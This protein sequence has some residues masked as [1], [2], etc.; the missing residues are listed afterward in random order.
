MSI[1]ELSEFTRISKYSRYLPEKQRRESWK[2]Q[3]DRMMDMHKTHLESLEVF[4]NVKDEWAFAKDMLMKKRVLGSQRALQFGGDAT[5]K[6]NARIYNC[7]R[8]DTEF[9]TIN[10][11]KSFYD[12]SHGD[13]TKVLT[14][15]GEWKNAIVKSYGKQNINQITLKNG[16]GSKRVY[17]TE[18]H[19]WILNDGS[20]TENLKI[21]DKLYKRPNIFN[22][23]NYDDATPDERLYWSYGFIYGDGTTLKNKDGNHTYSMVRLC[24]EKIKYKYRFEELNFKT[25]TSNS[26]N[27]DYMAY[28]GTYLKTLPDPNIDDINILRAFVRGFLDADGEKN[29]NYSKDGTGSIFKTIQNSDDKA[30]E[31]IRKVFPVVGVYINSESDIIKD[32][33][34]GKLYAKKFSINTDINKFSPSWSVTD[35]E[36]N[37]CSETVWCLEVDDNKS[38]VMPNGIVTGNCAFHYADRIR[39]FQETMYMALCGCGVGYSVQ[40]H[41]IKKLPKIQH[42]RK[43]EN[44][45]YTI[46]DSIEGWADAIGVLVESFFV[47]KS[48]WSGY[49]VLFDY[50][51]IRPAGAIIKSSGSK[52]PG[53]DGLRRTIDHIKKI[54]Y[55]ALNDGSKKLSTLQVHDIICHIADAVVSGGIR[56]AALISLFSKDDM[57]MRNC[58]TGKWFI[59]NPQ[60]GRANNSVLLI[61]DETTE[62]EFR[63]IITSV[64]E[65]GEPGF[66]FSD[67][68]EIGYNP[69]AEIGLYPVDVESGKSGVEFCNLSEINAKKC[70][71]LEDFMDSA[72]AAAILGTFQA[73]YSSFP[74]LGEITEKIVAKEALLGV[75]ITGMQDNPDIVLD[76]TNQR[77]AAQVVKNTNKEIA[78]KIGI[79]QA[80]RT[81]TVKP[82]GTSSIILSTG[83]SGIHPNHAKRYIRR[84]QCNNQEEPLQFFKKYNPRAIEKSV[85]DTNGVTDVISFLCEVPSQARTKNDINALSLLENVKS[86]WVNWV[87]EGKNQ[88]LC[89][90][91]SLSHNVSNTINILEGEWETVAEYIYYNRKFFAGISLLPQEGDKI[92]PQA[93]F[94]TV[95]TPKEL[96][97][98][99][100]DASVFAS[101]LIIHA[102]NAFDKNLYA[103]CDS[104][105]GIGEKLEIPDIQNSEIPDSIDKLTKILEKQMWV[106]RA[107]KF[108]NNYFNG[109]KRQMT[110]CL[111]DVDAWKTW[112]DVGREYVEVPWD[113]FNED[114]DNTKISEDVACSGGSCT[115]THI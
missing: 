109:D 111:K 61:R 64:K 33:N 72:K 36:E 27:G 85:W 32:T 53:P 3:V 62:E 38:F 40:K 55:T 45:T 30:Q 94:Q 39:T 112:C 76:P 63:E 66:I 41:H 97:D 16:R 43:G 74:Y 113:E 91:P 17:A 104:Y 105:L 8:I 92:Y 100:G 51:D 14:H 65:Y 12:F 98:M 99:Y 9:I 15:T 88:E 95:Y 86:T 31:F 103:A 11:V 42:E 75:S 34:Y 6:H 70:K 7:F 93:P 50:S 48:E 56:R 21:E 110:F 52:A 46:P 19:T 49:N 25:S 26:L 60:R 24:A 107:D 58:K 28:T 59:E 82:S 68:T 18:N 44:I 102:Q 22:D 69:C 79:N 89:A 87:D 114:K 13:K 80:A 23:W 78:A 20:R 67:S 71:T 54:F 108:A 96:V 83:A 37:I 84:V 106:K 29:R 90:H 4:E 57:E 81:T 101:G 47:C 1:K 73:S 115:L 10:G 2:E 5:L 77:L 35:I